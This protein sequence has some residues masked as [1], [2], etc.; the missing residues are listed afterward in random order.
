M[1]KRE[2]TIRDIAIKLDISVSTVSRAL[3]NMPEVNEKTRIKVLAMA[4][5]LN[6]EPNRVAQSLRIRRT[7]TIGV[8][9]PE[10]EMHFFSSLVA[11]KKLQTAWDLT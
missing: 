11:Y 9:V 8:I 10:V 7:N 4:E 1:S 6:Y 5:E 3:R 2:S